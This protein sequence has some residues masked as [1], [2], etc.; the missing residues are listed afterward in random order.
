MLNLTAQ[1]LLAVAG[2]A[3]WH[4]PLVIESAGPLPPG[5][6]ECYWTASKCRQDRWGYE[7]H[8]SRTQLSRAAQG[9]SF[10]QSGAGNLTALCE[11][12]LKG[13]LLARVWGAVIALYDRRKCVTENGPIVRSVLQGHAEARRRVLT[14]LLNN[15]SLPPHDSTLLNRLRQRCERWTDV[16]LARL[17]ISGDA[18]EFACDPARYA[19][20]T[21]EWPAA[22]KAPPLAQSRAALLL[23]S[24]QAAFTSGD[25]PTANSDLNAR[26]AES[27]LSCFPPTAFDD[28]GTLR[29][30]WEARLINSTADAEQLVEQ[31]LSADGDPHTSPRWPRR[32]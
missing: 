19:D 28:S 4:G 29:T 31:L 6:I 11:E 1:D 18:A 5:A 25:A 7:L 8:E 22:A 10:K 26:I 3:A 15:Q 24:Y 2:V 23:T 9:Y 32:G 12:I 16:L 14:L 30:L 20:F 13:E 27:I 17:A 21:E